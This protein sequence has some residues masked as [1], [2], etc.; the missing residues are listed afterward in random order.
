MGKRGPAWISNDLKVVTFR[1][2][3]W[4]GIFSWYWL[5]FSRYFTNQYRRKTRLVHFG[6]IKLAGAPFSLLKG[7]LWT[8][9]GA[10]RLWFLWKYRYTDTHRTVCK[11]FSF[12]HQIFLKSA[13]L[14]CI[15]VISLWNNTDRHKKWPFFYLCEQINLS[16][17]QIRKVCLDA[18]HWDLSRYAFARNIA[19]LCAK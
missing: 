5:V 14:F 1:V 16:A 17:A 11:G 19:V 18:K 3:Y 4:F 9:F 15:I 6:I 13:C 7:G 2:V 12:A 8:P 10:L